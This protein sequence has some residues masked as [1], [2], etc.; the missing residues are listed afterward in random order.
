MP[1]M[2]HEARHQFTGAQVER[3]LVAGILDAEE[4]FEL[5]QGDL[6]LVPPQGPVHAGLVERLDAA[7][8]L[9]YPGHRVRAGLPMVASP[10]SEPEPD[11]A[12]AR[13]PSELRHP[14]CQDAVLVIEVSFTSLQDDRGKARI[15]AQGGVPEYWIIDVQGR[16]LEQYIDPLRDGRYQTRR[17]LGSTDIV[18]LPGTAQEWSVASLLP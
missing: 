10:D 13:G 14:R 7:L 12:V 15:Y 4:R 18:M 11:L 8:R 9:V 5:L 17:V 3:M 1:G 2:A 16:K 6:V